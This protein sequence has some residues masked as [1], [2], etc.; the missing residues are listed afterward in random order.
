MK[1]GTLSMVTFSKTRIPERVYKKNE[2]DQ[3][4]MYIKYNKG[5][6][7]YLFSGIVELIED[8]EGYLNLDIKLYT[9]EEVCKVKY[10]KVNDNRGKWFKDEINNEYVMTIR[11][12]DIM[13]ERYCILIKYFN[14]SYLEIGMGLCPGDENEFDILLNNYKL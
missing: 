2:Q 10:C 14:K 13:D 1:L 12:V 9:G 6:G 7:E 11:K 3:D 5:W 4:I 8:N